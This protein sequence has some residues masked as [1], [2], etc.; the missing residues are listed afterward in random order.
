MEE[1]ISH[2]GQVVEGRG[3]PH[4]I[5]RELILENRN[6]VLEVTSVQKYMTEMAF[7]YASKI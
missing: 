5:P 7:Q 3:I 4:R 1:T 6:F 2:A